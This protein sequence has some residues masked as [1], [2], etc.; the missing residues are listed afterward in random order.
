VGRR[1]VRQM[2]DTRWTE[3]EYC[4][5]DAA[6]IRDVDPFAGY[7]GDWHLIS[8]DCDPACRNHPAIDPTALS[9][10]LE[11]EEVGKSEKNFERTLSGDHGPLPLREQLEQARRL[12]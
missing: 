12:K 4:G 8:H 6:F 7:E 10:Q 9:R 5:G 2:K 3:C 1:L 11:E